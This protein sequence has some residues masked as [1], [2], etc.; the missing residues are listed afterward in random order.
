MADSV[1][2]DS[3][4]TNNKTLIGAVAM[5]DRGF[6]DSDMVFVLWVRHRSAFAAEHHK[7]A[8]VRA[9]R[10]VPCAQHLLQRTSFEMASPFPGTFRGHHDVDWHWPVGPLLQILPFNNG[11]HRFAQMV[12]QQ[13]RFGAKE[14]DVILFLPANF[15]CHFAIR[16]GLFLGGE[17]PRFVGKPS[18]HASS[19]YARESADGP[20]RGSKLRA[21]PPPGFR[22]CR[23]KARHA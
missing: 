14:D 13:V 10:I 5:A 15:L 18:D 4:S 1:D 9:C 7:R 19:Q 17:K 20:A 23:Q 16:P 2:V 12:P 3:A 8:I 22:T 11:L 21:L 6:F